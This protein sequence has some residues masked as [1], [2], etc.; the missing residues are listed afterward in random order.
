MGARVNYI[1]DDGSEAITVLYSHWGADSIAEDLDMAF[2]H[3]LKRKGDY[4]YWTR[5]VISYLIKDQL[6]EDTGFAIFAIPRTE[7][8]ELDNW[9][10][11]VVIFCETATHDYER[12]YSYNG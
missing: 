6:L 9:G 10:E 1:F 5:M 4:G 3:A 11:N 8:S 2:E 12:S 7:I